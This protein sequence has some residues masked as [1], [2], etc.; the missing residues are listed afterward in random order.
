LCVAAI[1]ALGKNRSWIGLAFE[2]L[3]SY[4]ELMLRISSLSIVVLLLL[5]PAATSGGPAQKR[6]VPRWH[7]YGFLPGY[8]QPPNNT[9]PVFGPKG[10]ATGE[11]DYSPYYYG[12]NGERYYFGRPGFYR[13]RYNGGSFGP[14]W[15]WTPIGLA[16]NCG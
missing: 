7:G 14:C 12:Y 3:T 9:V 11:P 5:L 15:S 1:E 8:H 16:W 2:R 6:H 13:G 10:A 4:S